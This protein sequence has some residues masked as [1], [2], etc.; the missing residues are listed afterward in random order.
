MPNMKQI[1]MKS[2]LVEKS[3]SMEAFNMN[4]SHLMQWEDE[5]DIN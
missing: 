1:S 2:S 5:I 3:F 4:V